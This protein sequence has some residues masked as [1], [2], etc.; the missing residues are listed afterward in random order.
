MGY[1]DLEDLDEIKTISVCIK[2]RFCTDFGGFARL[3]NFCP[4]YS[5]SPLAIRVNL[6]HP[7]PS[8][9]LYGLLLRLLVFL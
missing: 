4:D 9:L 8:L 5:S 3:E 6:L 2:K 7:K 1:G